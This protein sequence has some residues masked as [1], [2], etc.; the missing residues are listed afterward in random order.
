MCVVWR[1]N[2]GVGLWLQVVEGRSLG[3]LMALSLIPSG[4]AI[5]SL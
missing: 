2:V 4:L 5:G 3:E 1:P